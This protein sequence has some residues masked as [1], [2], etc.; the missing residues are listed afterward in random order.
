MTQTR[1]IKPLFF[2]RPLTIVSLKTP[3]DIN[4]VF[5]IASIVITK[6]P[7][8]NA[9]LLPPT[10]KAFPAL[11]VSA[12]AAPGVKVHLDFHPQG[13]AKGPFFAAFISGLDTFFVPIHGPKNEVVIPSGLYGVVFAV[14]TTD[15]TKVDDSVTVAGPAFLN[16]NF[17]SQGKLES[18]AI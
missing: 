9:A 14:I 6:C 4:Q 18:W 17:N 7:D 16:F 11:S 12:N 3:F 13:G 2:I 1:P 10:L 5:T 8:G 15:Q